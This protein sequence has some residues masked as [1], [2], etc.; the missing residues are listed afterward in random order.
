MTSRKNRGPSRQPD[1]SLVGYPP[2][3][4]VVVPE[5]RTDSGTHRSMNHA[6]PRR[7]RKTQSV[8]VVD[9]AGVEYSTPAGSTTNTDWVFLRLRGGAWF[10]DRWVPESVRD[11]GTTTPGSGG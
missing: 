11:S 6:P 9:P 5:S 4:G 8:L 2:E 1:D 7:R 3:P 10:I